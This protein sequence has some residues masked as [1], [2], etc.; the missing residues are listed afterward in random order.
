MWDNSR[1]HI[2]RLEF[3][4]S[5]E[6]ISIISKK[7]NSLFSISFCVYIKCV[8]V[9]SLIDKQRPASI[10]IMKISNQFFK[11]RRLGKRRD[12]CDNPVHAICRVF[13]HAQWPRT[14]CSSIKRN[15]VDQVPPDSRV[16][17]LRCTLPL[18]LSPKGL[19]IHRVWRRGRAR[20]GEHFGSRW[21]NLWQ[22]H[23]GILSLLY[24]LISHTSPLLS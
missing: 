13:F 15:R 5:N 11:K 14:K 16:T 8:K 23:R 2:S 3:L 24:T 10:K 17:R 20:I 21:R 1:K 22:M 19:N 7:C 6:L 18:L 12:P 9:R 4:K